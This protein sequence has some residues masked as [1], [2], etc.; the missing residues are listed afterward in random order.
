MRLV[1]NARIFTKQ[2]LKLILIQESQILSDSNLSHKYENTTTQK[3]VKQQKKTEEGN[4]NGIKHSWPKGK[5][6]VIGDS[7]VAG[8]DE[9]KMSSKRLIKVRSFQGATCS[10]MYHWYLFL[11]ENPT[12]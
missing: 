12:M 11:K 2:T 8:I 3:L 1:C 6:V 9:R 10:D 7:I 5:C 4:K